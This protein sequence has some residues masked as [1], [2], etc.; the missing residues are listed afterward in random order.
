MTQKVFVTNVLKHEQEEVL[1]AGSHL[2]YIHMAKQNSTTPLY[3]L[4]LAVLFI[5]L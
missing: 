3:V 4:Y 5:S 1:M 2:I